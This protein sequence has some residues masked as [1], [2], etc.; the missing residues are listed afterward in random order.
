MK[1]LIGPTLVLATLPAFAHEGH[2]LFGSHWH[3]TDALGF[4]GVA[5]LVGFAIWMSRK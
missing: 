3:A 1:H 5:A 2:G 4:V